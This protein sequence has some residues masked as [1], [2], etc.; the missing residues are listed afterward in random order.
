MAKTST[1]F[2]SHQV[3]DVIQIVAGPFAGKV[4]RQL[5]IPV[6]ILVKIDRRQIVHGLHMLDRA[7]FSRADDFLRQLHMLIFSG[8][9][10]TTFELDCS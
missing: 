7:E 2:E 8:K 9:E 3:G 5:F 10:T 6:P 4:V 1:G